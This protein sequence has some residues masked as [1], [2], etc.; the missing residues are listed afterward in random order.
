MITRFIHTALTFNR[1]ITAELVIF[2]HAFRV[3]VPLPHDMRRIT[4]ISTIHNGD[5][6]ILICSYQAAA[7]T[8]KLK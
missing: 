3:H 4:N 5:E 2:P 6:L 1:S 8:E 7:L